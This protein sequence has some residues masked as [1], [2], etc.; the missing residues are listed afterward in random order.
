[1][2]TAGEKVVSNVTT[3]VLSCGG[4]GCVWK[5]LPHTKKLFQN[6]YFY[7]WSDFD[8]SG[9]NRELFGSLSHVTQ[10]A[11]LFIFKLLRERWCDISDYTLWCR[12]FWYLLKKK[13][14][15]SVA[16]CC[17]RT[18]PTIL[19]S[20]SLV[21]GGGKRQIFLFCCLFI[22][23]LKKKY[24]T[25]LEPEILPFYEDEKCTVKRQIKIYF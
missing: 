14:K 2:L 4:G 21:W 22:Q 10:L 25:I 11:Y 1:M 18:S 12:L 24:C 7:V 5:V 13:L 17:T 20:F 16:C 15:K 8:R 3:Q 6:K 19:F 9:A 23:D